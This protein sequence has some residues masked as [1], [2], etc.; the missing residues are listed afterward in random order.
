MPATRAPRRGASFRHAD[1]YAG[2]GAVRRR[3]G[4]VS[5]SPCSP[6]IRSCA[7]SGR[8]PCCSSSSTRTSRGHLALSPLARGVPRAGATRRV[9][10]DHRLGAVG[11]VGTG[12]GRCSLGR[13]LR[14]LLLA[15][16]RRARPCC[17]AAFM[18]DAL[19][20]ARRLRGARTMHALTVL[21]LAVAGF[22]LAVGVCYWLGV[23]AVAALLLYE[24]L[25][26]ARA[27]SGASTRR[28]SR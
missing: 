28:S 21:G 8:F 6:S 13:G 4:R 2:V 17:G 19:R 25:S 10:G 22:G 16:R 20:R 12:S 14:P 7:G 1:A 27:T 5:L 11:G 26:S 15:L 23:A 18:G 9:A 3:P 24:H